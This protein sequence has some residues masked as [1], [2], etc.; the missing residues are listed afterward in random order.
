MVF[1]RLPELVVRRRLGHFR[2]RVEQLCLGAVQVFQLVN[3]HVVERL[4]LHASSFS[5]RVGSQYHFPLTK[6]PKAISPIRAM[7]IPRIRLQKIAT[8]MPTIT[9]IP[10]TLIP[11]MPPRRPRSTA[12]PASLRWCGRWF[13]VSR[14]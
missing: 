1:E 3:E 13:P 8:T 2:Q 6:P 7:M 14:G 5:P 11:P 9:R 10:P 4:Q 12:I